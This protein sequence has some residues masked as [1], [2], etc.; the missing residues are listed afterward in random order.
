MAHSTTP[1]LA[2][3]TAAS[4][5]HDPIC[6]EGYARG[7]VYSGA[8]GDTTHDAI[9]SCSAVQFWTAA[10]RG[11][12]Y[13]L[14]HTSANAAISVTLTDST[15]FQIPS[16]IFGANYLKMVA[17]GASWTAHCSFSEI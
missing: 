7:H 8:V 15:H 10:T 14:A 16:A 4:T 9:G 17:V 13:E 3:N 6:I 11:G 12:N 1:T 5:T 2:L